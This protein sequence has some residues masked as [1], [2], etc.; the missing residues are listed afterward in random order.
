[1]DSS[2]FAASAVMAGHAKRR[3]KPKL[4]WVA[5]CGQR[6][7]DRAK[8]FASIDR[9]LRGELIRKE[10]RDP[11]AKLGKRKEQTCSSIAEHRHRAI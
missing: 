6:A 4:S 9:R 1:M 2:R 11:N 8:A 5:N 10:G 3:A 7:R